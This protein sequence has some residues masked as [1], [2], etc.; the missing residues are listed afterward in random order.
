VHIVEGSP[1]THIPRFAA[2]NKC[3][4]VVMCTD[5]SE[6]GKVAMGGLTERVF[7]YLRVPLLVVH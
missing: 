5:G 3:N 4:V 7:Q 1:V 6:P 2:N